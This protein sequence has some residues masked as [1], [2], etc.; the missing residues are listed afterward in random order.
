MFSTHTEVDDGLT[1]F[2]RLRPRLLAI[3][4]RMLGCTAAAE[5]IVQDVWVRW[6]NTDR[7]AVRDPGAFLATATTRMAINVM[8][9][10]RSRR[11]TCAGPWLPEP[12]DV[13]VDPRGDVERGQALESG[14]ALLR[15]TLSPTE[16]TAFILREAFELA[17]REIAVKLGLREANARQVVTRARQR[18]AA[19]ALTLSLV[20]AASA[21]AGQ[22]GPVRP[23][24]TKDLTGVPGREVTMVTVDYKP[25]ESS[26]AHTH[27]AQAL[28]YV[29]EGSI[30]MQLKGQEP[31]TLTAGQT[32][33]EG[34]DDV[35]VVSR[36]ASTTKP[37]KYVVVLVKDKGAP[38][39]TPIN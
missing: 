1:T 7:D 35:H 25:G 32:F 20:L 30:V 34:L 3:A 9:S 11:E 13:S 29:L 6:Q 39:L 27:H 22:D 28:L 23:L 17:Y 19:A 5:D 2:L 8:R 38:V 37:A 24:M 26:P 33:Y 21:L 4:R 10:A 15:E 36:N 18:V 12:V 31:V 16:R 14:V